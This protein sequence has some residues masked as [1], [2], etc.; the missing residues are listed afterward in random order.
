MCHNDQVP[1]SEGHDNRVQI[2]DVPCATW[3]CFKSE[4]NKLILSDSKPL[5]EKEWVFRGVLKR[6]PLETTLERACDNWKI[7]LGHLP[8]IEVELIREIKRKAFGLGIPLPN[9]DDYMWWVSLMQHYGAPTRLLDFTYSPYVA[10]YFALEKLLNKREAH[11]AAVWAVQHEFTQIGGEQIADQEL[12]GKIGR[13]DVGCLDFLFDP[14]KRLKPS[15]LQV[16]AYYLHDRITAQQGTFLCP[17]DIAVP[18]VSNFRSVPG[19]QD[20]NRVQ[21]FILPRTMLNDA[22]AELQKMNITRHSLFPGIG[23]LAASLSMR[24]LYFAD[25]AE[26]KKSQKAATDGMGK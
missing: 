10:A 8:R 11:D 5:E 15:V 6:H 13:S 1:N 25:L 17:T 9:R 12:L 16:T 3:D 21:R 24:L 7:P 23:G 22:V 4:V 20:E 19:Y 18:F 14:N 26:Y 2:K